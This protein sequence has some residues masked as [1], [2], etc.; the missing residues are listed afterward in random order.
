[1]AENR[2]AREIEPVRPKSARN[3]GSVPKRYRSQTSNPD[4]TIAGFVCLR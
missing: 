3:N 2:L 4:T 1:M